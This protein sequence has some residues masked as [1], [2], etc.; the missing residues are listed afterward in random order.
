M[1]GSDINYLA[2]K[3]KYILFLEAGEESLGTDESK[4]IDIFTNR[5]FQHLNLVGQR[6]KEV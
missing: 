1:S 3:V 6:Y 4:F 2:Q 5:S